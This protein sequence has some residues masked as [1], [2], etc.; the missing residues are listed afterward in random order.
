MLFE[1]SL[2]ADL[3]EDAERVRLSVQRVALEKRASKS[4]KEP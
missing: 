2:N 4:L 1:C 3:D